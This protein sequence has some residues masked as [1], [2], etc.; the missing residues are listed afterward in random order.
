M[1]D[2]SA[3]GSVEIVAKKIGAEGWTLT[4]H[5]C[6]FCGGRVLQSGI[7]FMC[8]TCEARC[9]HA[10]IGICGCGIMPAARPKGAPQG[11]FTC[12]PNPNRGPSS[13]AVYVVRYGAEEA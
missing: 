7:W 11:P 9:T 5:A 4:T 12:A 1:S 3:T 2:D 10:P 6:R 8:A 13:P